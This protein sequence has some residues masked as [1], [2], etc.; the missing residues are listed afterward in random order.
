MNPV[1]QSVLQRLRRGLG[2]QGFRQIA[3]LFIR[4][5]EV[6]LFLSFWGA[7]R[8]GEWLMVAAIPAYLAMADGGFTGTTQREMTMRMGAGDRPGALAAFQSTWVL[9]LILSAVLL[10]LTFLAVTLLPFDHWLKLNSMPGNTLSIVILLLVAHIVL[11]FQ[12]GLVYGGYS[13]EGR[14]SRG[15]ILGTWMYLF[16]FAGLALA[17]LFGGGPVAAAMGFLAGRALGLLLFLVDL[18]RVAPWLRFGFRHASKM[19]MARLFRPSLASMAFPLGEALNIQGMRLVVGLVLGPV[20]VAVFSSLRTL[21][22]S[23]MKPVAVVSLLIEPELALAYGAG[24]RELVKSLFLRAS[25]LTVWLVLPACLLLWFLGEVVLEIWASGEITLDAPL[26]ACLLLASAVNSLWYVSL[27]VPYATNRHGR[28]ALFS[29][30]ANGGMLLFAVFF[31]AWF[32]LSG[33]GAAVL[34]AEL[35]MTVF[36]LPVAL[37]QSSVTLNFWLGK[38]LR[39]PSFPHF[40]R[41]NTSSRRI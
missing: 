13:C 32:G 1:H 22:R 37:S 23:A 6:P 29:L 40:L 7:E 17:V 20:A 9:L 39:P 34:L 25:Q 3:N 33:A 8:Y 4:L 41:R 5:A 30:A 27:M 12:S 10:G 21:C 36:V 28:V 26:Y 35:S 31:M 14:Y 16:D 38:I 24:N 18:P 15:M 19:Q 11:G 2:A